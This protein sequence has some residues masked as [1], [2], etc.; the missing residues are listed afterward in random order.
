MKTIRL[1]EYDVFGYQ[2]NVEI[3]LYSGRFFIEKSF[4]Y[5]I[6][7]SNNCTIVRTFNFT[8]ARKLW[9]NPTHT[10]TQWEKDDTDDNHLCHWAKDRINLKMF[11]FYRHVYVYFIEWSSLSLF[12]Q[13]SQM[14]FFCFSFQFQFHLAFYL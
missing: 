4:N 14:N 11:F 2:V 12:F 3:E 6:L 1:A 7:L 8:G 9:H 13:L 5:P 10:H